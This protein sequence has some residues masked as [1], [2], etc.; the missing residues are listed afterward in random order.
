MVHTWV[1]VN[2]EC[3]DGV[4]PKFSLGHLQI[5]VVFKDI[6]F[7]AC[8]CNGRVPAQ[9]EHK[10]VFSHLFDLLKNA[11]MQLV[12]VFL[13]EIV[14]FG[15]WEEIGLHVGHYGIFLF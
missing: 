12:E 14:Q 15:L 2:F 6:D 8:G 9:R 11:F 10:S 4:L 7:H 13:L 3:L 1:R 5:N